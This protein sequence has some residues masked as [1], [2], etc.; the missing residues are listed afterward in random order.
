MV[1]VLKYDDEFRLLQ[2]TY[3]YSWDFDSNHLHTVLLEPIP[4]PQ[5][6]PRATNCLSPYSPSTTPFVATTNEG[7]TIC[8]SF[9]RSR[10]CSFTDCIYEHVCNR[11]VA[12]GGGGEA[13]GQKH[14]SF[15]HNSNIAH[16]Q[17]PPR[18]AQPQ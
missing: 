13:C 11:R 7:R 14:A 12:W 3:N 16:T 17:Q 8:R 9:N 1:S 15:T 10:G 18:P 5:F 2:A 6:T 4:K